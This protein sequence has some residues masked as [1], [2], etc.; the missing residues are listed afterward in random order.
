MNTGKVRNLFLILIALFLLPNI[1]VEAASTCT[2][3]EKNNLIQ[4][5]Y[6]I[7]IDYELLP[8]MGDDNRP[9]KLTISNLTPNMEVHYDE[10]IYKY[11]TVGEGNG[12][13]IIK[14]SETFVGGKSYKIGIYSSKKSVCGETF[15]TSR[16]ISIPKFNAFSEQEECKTYPDFKYCNK[17]YEGTITKETFKKELEKYKTNAND[18]KTEEKIKKEKDTIFKKINDLIKQNLILTIVSSITIVAIVV[19]IIRKHNKKKIKID[20]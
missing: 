18:T 14:M 13:G 17:W 2:T 10:S 9:F 3:Q 7:K 1:K 11:D 19:I 4:L 5:A 8:N 6:N 12:N 16:Y 15:L 20:F